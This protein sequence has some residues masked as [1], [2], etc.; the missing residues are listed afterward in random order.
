MRLISPSAAAAG[1][2]AAG[3]LFVSSAGAVTVFTDR[4]VWETA[5]G[6]ATTTDDPFDNDIGFDTIPNASITFDSGVVSANSGGS[7][8]CEDNSVHDSLYVNAVDGGG[9]DAS[10]NIVWTFPEDI[11]AFGA[12]WFSTTTGG[13]LTVTGDFDGTGDQTVDFSAFLGFGGRV[14]FLGFIGLASFDLVTFETVSLEATEAFRADNLSFASATV[15]PLPAGLPLL[16]TG[17]LALGLV[18]ARRRKAA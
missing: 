14:G 11:F 1:L 9:N 16:L 2:L 12:D 13:L 8:C 18:G 6:G 17:L 5:L 7:P 10:L 15:I 4:T 3:F